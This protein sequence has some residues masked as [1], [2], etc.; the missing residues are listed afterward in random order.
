MAAGLLPATLASSAEAEIP[1]WAGYGPAC[2]TLAA[3][4]QSTISNRV[5]FMSTIPWV[6]DYFG[7]SHPIIAVRCGKIKQRIGWRVPSYELRYQSLS[8]WQMLLLETR[9]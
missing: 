4:A 1:D 3:Q 7:T 8:A 9:S 5:A 2:A 6:T